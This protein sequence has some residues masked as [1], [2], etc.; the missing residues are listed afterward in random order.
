[1]IEITDFPQEWSETF[2]REN[3]EVSIMFTQYVS[4]DLMLIY[5]FIF[6]NMQ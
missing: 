6:I 4:F 1:M 2:L 3:N 5:L